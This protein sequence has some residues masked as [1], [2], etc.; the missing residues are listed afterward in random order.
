MVF[1]FV[2]S[3][4]T[5]WLLPCSPG[6]FI[7]IPHL[8][9]WEGGPF[10]QG[11]GEA[12][13]GNAMFS[14][15]SAILRIKPRGVAVK[16]EIVLWWDESNDITAGS[17]GFHWSQSFWLISFKAELHSLKLSSVWM[18]WRWQFGKRQD[19]RY[20]HHNKF[21]EGSTFVIIA[22]SCYVIHIFFRTLTV[23]AVT[24]NSTLSILFWNTE[25]FF[26]LSEMIITEFVWF[27]RQ[28]HSCACT[29]I[30]DH[31]HLH[32]SAFLPFLFLAKIS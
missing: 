2:D 23:T 1:C 20:K 25:Y 16:F 6:G 18:S 12:P 9:T 4:T 19:T 11:W 3:E 31:S 27:P 7:H 21:R 8:Q 14:H 17:D 10:F 26:F 5:T 32:W 28:R 13:V 22:H 29:D 30:L 24:L 15:T